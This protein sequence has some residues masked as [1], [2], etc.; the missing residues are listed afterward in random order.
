MYS[1]SSAGFQGL[2]TWHRDI[3]ALLAN[4]AGAEAFEQQG[5]DYLS[6]KHFLIYNKFNI[7]HNRIFK[8]VWSL[9]DTGQNHTA[10]P[11][12]PFVK[13]VVATA[14]NQRPRAHQS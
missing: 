14:I 7:Y 8:D 12:K 3:V 2:V 4:P 1:C 9:G 6:L 5:L 11:F 13:T 10:H